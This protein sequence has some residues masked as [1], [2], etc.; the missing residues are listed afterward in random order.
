MPICTDRHRFVFFQMSY[1]FTTSSAWFLSAYRSWTTGS[2][3]LEELKLSL[4]EGVIMLLRLG[5]LWPD[6]GVEGA[7]EVRRGVVGMLGVSTGV[8][9]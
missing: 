6:T 4:P 3:S 9:G 2:N 7:L 8:D 1:V 5:K